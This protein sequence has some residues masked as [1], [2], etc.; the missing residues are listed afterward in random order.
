MKLQVPANEETKK[1]YRPV[2]DLVV[3]NNVEHVVKL[4]PDK[5]L[6]STPLKNNSNAFEE[7]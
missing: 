5:A 1:P 6:L 7:H 3:V 4:V 2:L